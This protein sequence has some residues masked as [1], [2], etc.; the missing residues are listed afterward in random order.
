MSYRMKVVK[1]PKTDV[2]PTLQTSSDSSL[3]SSVNVH[4]LQDSRAT[5]PRFAPS[6]EDFRSTFISAVDP[7]YFKDKISTT[8]AETLNPLVS[9]LCRHRFVEF[10]RM[11]YEPVDDPSDRMECPEAFISR[12][13]LHH[14]E[15]HHHLGKYADFLGY[16]KERELRRDIK[17]LLRHDQ[18][19]EKTTA[20]PSEWEKLHTSLNDTINFLTAI[21]A[22]LQQNNETRLAG[23][24]GEKIDELKKMKSKIDVLCGPTILLHSEP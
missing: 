16:H 20:E 1:E 2:S 8:L 21:E 19:C 6:L 3:L 22:G 9:H 24:V 17:K 12:N 4:E 15:Q 5:V 7:S 23:D 10:G 13:L 11:K 14:M 18:N